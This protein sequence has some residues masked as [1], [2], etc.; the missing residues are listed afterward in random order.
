MSVDLERRT[1]EDIERERALLARGGERVNRREARASREQARGAREQEEVNR[2]SAESR[3]TMSGWPPDLDDAID[4]VRD[5]RRRA[6]L[7]I[8][9]VAASEDRIAH[10]LEELAAGRPD[11]REEYRRAAEQAR[12]AAREAQEILRAF[13]Q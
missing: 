3:R 1:L 7:A 6:R 2:E 13:T 12:K 4:R 11:R 9:A 5:S 8:Q 10:V